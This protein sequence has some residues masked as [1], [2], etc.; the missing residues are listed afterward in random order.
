VAMEILNGASEENLRDISVEQRR[1]FRF[2]PRKFRKRGRFL[3]LS[4]IK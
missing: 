3:K 4:P 1:E 2:S